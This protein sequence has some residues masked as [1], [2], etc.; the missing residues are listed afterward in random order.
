MKTYQQIQKNFID[1]RSYTLYRDVENMCWSTFSLAYLNESERS[2]EYIQSLDFSRLE[3][4]RK[5]GLP[6][7]IEL[8]RGK[9]TVKFRCPW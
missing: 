8:T 7:T 5:L 9:E 1:L 2:L 6:M 3:A 4:K